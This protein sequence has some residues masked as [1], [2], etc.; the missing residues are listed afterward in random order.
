MAEERERRRRDSRPGS[1]LCCGPC[2]RVTRWCSGQR[3][4]LTGFAA[5]SHLAWSGTSE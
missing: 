1:V 3:S 2:R 4:E 5:A